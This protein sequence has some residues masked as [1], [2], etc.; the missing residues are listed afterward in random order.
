M[1]QTLDK[2][3]DEQMGANFIA[4]ARRND[5][6][7]KRLA[8]STGYT[9]NHCYMLLRGDALFKSMTLGNIAHAYGSQAVAEILGEYG[10]AT[11]DES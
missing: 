6:D 3:S 8:R 4:W 2:I 10:N 7:A 1:N 11:G 5:I 9:E